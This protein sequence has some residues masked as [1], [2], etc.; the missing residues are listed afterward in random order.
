MRTLPFSKAWL[1][2]ALLWV[3][4]LLNYSDRLMVTT[5]RLSL[6]EAIPM[7]D[8]QFGLLTSVFLWI[9]GGLSP[10]AGFLAD[11]FSRSRVIV[12]SLL[13]WS[14]ATA[15]TA[16]AQSWEQLLL[17]RV[18]M[19]ISE[20]CYIPAALALIA[21]YHR[22]PTRS[23]ATAIHMTGIFVGSALGGLGGWIAERYGWCEPFRLFGIAG[24]AYACLLAFTLRDAARNDAPGGS[25]GT[26][27]AGGLGAA[28]VSLLSDGRFIVLM[29]YW[30]VLGM[31]GWTLVGWLPTYM[32][33]Q[34]E[35]GQG[36]AGLTA[37]GYFQMAAFVGVLF[38]GAWADWWSRSTQRARML[39]P[40]IGLCIAAPAVLLVAR[41]DVLTLAIAGL[42][43]CGFGRSFCDAN[44]MPILC[45]VAN[46]RYRATGYGMLNAFS[47]AAG[48]AMIYV[49]GALKDLHVSLNIVL[50][51][52]AGCLLA[53]AALLLL[54]K[55]R[56]VD[57]GAGVGASDD[58]PP[59]SGSP[60]VSRLS[61][62]SADA[63]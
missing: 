19:G 39:V 23:L 63:P 14:L 43:V 27:A 29:V 9:Y 40:A 5:M 12:G 35:L 47:C 53:C 18:V 24:L 30:T 31:A 17:S 59:Q 33:E 10:V 37:T 52:A 6:K 48:G 41:T 44:M 15:L 38:G 56:H 54:V 25:A 26:P 60:V 51:L 3:V 4:A 13:I 11:R 8:A 49:G 34:F 28:L 16:Y 32:N 58:V 22:G 62:D 46:P 36:A 61:A 50:Q 42:I 1:V 21:D 20:A 2:V 55:P 45:L 57:D 7:T